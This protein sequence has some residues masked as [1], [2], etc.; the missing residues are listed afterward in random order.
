MD[1]SGKSA[2]IFVYD[3]DFH[4]DS[5]SHGFSGKCF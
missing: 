2:I 5:D 3:L 1:F 4:P